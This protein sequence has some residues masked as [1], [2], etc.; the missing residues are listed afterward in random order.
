MTIM[1]LFFYHCLY[2]MGDRITMRVFK[3]VFM[4]SKKRLANPSNIFKSL[5]HFLR[6]IITLMYFIKWSFCY[7]PEVWGV[8][9]R[10]GK[11]DSNSVYIFSLIDSYLTKCNAIV[12]AH[13]VQFHVYLVMRKLQ[14]KYENISPSELMPQAYSIHKVYDQDQVLRS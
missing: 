14:G 2:L 12:I 7:Y 1:F 3:S 8:T 4:F 10:M 13:N 11:E 9:L 6:N 5:S